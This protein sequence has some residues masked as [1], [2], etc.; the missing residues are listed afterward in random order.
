MAKLAKK[1]VRLA[2]RRSNAVRLQEEKHIGRE[3]TDWADVTEDK[4]PRQIL[5]TLRHYGYFYDKKHYVEWTTDWMKTNRPEDLKDYKAAEDWRT[6]S[7]VAALCKMELNGCE[8]PE[9][10]KTFQTTALN[11]IIEYGKT[12]KVEIDPNAPEPVKRK[13]PSEL[14]GEKTNE[15]I[16]EIEGCID[17][18][19]LGTL[20][21]D[22]SI[23]DIMIKENSAAQTAHDTIRHYMSV[24]EEL[25]ELVED[26]TEDLVEGY[27]HLTPRKQKAFYKFICDLISDT[28]KFLLSKKATRKTRV[29][30]PTPALKQVSKVLYLPS[31]SEYKIAS[32]SPEKMVGAD[33]LYLFNTKTRQM[34]YLVSD[35]RNG[36]EVKGSTI[37]G[38]DVKNSFK[39]ML[40]K[41]EDYIATLAKATKSKALKE[42]R[43]LKTKESETDRRINRDTIILKVL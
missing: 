5:D 43:S 35:R 9:Q 25:R 3:T 40:R 21:K 34:K 37:I 42:L 17:D 11:E 38:F 28:E 13:S 31:S 19:G 32:V 16:G 14:L 15:F 20:D 8:L 23:Y 7:T 18:Y 26:K 10:N 24:Q 29:K 30:K 4:M 6:S 22:W 2:P 33:Q 39:K 1:T 36:F 27:S 12:V 41:P